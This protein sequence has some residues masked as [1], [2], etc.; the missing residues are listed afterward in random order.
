MGSALRGANWRGKK[1][2]RKDRVL[3][4]N[5]HQHT[6]EWLQCYIDNLDR[7]HIA[8]LCAR[9]AHHCGGGS[10]R[11]QS[12]VQQVYASSG[13]SHFEEKGSFG[14]R[15][16]TLGTT[17]NGYRGLASRGTTKHQEFQEVIIFAS[18]ASHT[19]YPAGGFLATLETPLSLLFRMLPFKSQRSIW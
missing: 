4:I 5:F 11:W 18:R 3:L 8:P 9:L 19:Q 17:I 14:L 16:A 2:L 7:G 13:V 1:G 6:A 15:G 10:K 12:A